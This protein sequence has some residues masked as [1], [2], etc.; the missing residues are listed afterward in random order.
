M[1]GAKLAWFLENG[2]AREGHGTDIAAPQIARATR[3]VLPRYP[4][5]L[6]FSVGDL[7]APDHLPR[8]EFD[9]VLANGVLHHIQNLERCVDA[10]CAALKPGGGLIASEFTGPQRYD[11]SKAEI[12]AINH[13]IAMLPPELRGPRFHP[14]QLQGKLAADSSEAVRTRDIA[15]VLTARFRDVRSLPY[16][17][18]IL[19]R[20]LTPRFFRNLRPDSPRH[21]DAVDRLL[22][23]DRTVAGAVPSHH[24]FFIARN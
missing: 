6:S 16:G 5:R 23:F 21:R 7:N 1:S 14:A 8:G 22:A 3:E 9:L 12:E 15:D 13:G 11:Y 20:A 24:H 18:N 17:G 10:L 19:M 2:F 4:G